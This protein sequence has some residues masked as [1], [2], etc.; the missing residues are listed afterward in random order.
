MATPAT[1]HRSDMV[2]RIMRDYAAVQARLP[3]AAVTREARGRAMHELSRL[4]WPT[5]SDEQW[6]YTNLRA[7]ERLPAFAPAALAHAPG[8]ASAVELPPP[9]PGFERLVY[10]DGVRSVAG[11]RTA[12]AAAAVPSAMWPAEQRL[13]LLCDMF[14]TDVAAFQIRGHSAIELLFV[15]SA[16]AAGA[17]SYPRLQL[18]LDPDSQ[19][20][21]VERHL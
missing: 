2:D 17:A 19:L 15:T 3:D 1:T 14:A 21:L 10:I 7:F 18:A 11:A 4:G 8:D 9:L 12:A 5:T 20:Q 6:R 16:A 13:G